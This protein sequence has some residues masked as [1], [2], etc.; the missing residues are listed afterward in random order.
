MTHVLCKEHNTNLSYCKNDIN[1]Q[2]GNENKT[3]LIG[4]ENLARKYVLNFLENDALST[5]SQ[6]HDGGITILGR[7]VKTFLTIPLSLDF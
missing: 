3:A 4:E 6:L 2:R 5:A 7:G 1:D